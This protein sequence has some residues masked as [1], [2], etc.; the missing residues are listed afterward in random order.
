M[1]DMLEMLGETNQGVL[2]LHHALLAFRQWNFW[3]NLVG[4]AE[5]GMGY[6]HD[7]TIQV[8]I[9]NPDHPITH[10][11]HPWTMTDETYTI[12]NATSQNND[13][14]LTTHH[15]QS[16]H[17]LA[18]TRQFKQARVFCYQSGH[19]HT[20]FNDPNF[21]AVLQRRKSYGWHSAL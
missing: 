5:R 4:I 3:S 6:H 7:Q 1:K 18:W 10:G 2:V 8:D 20:A 11:L 13:I 15:P 9:A 19:N 21:R 12:N 16:M 14:L 17:T